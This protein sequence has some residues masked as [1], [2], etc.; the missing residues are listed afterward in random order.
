MTTS[1][2]TNQRTSVWK[3]N[4]SQ[5]ARQE[6]GEQMPD[7]NAMAARPRGVFSTADGKNLEIPC[8]PDVP[9]EQVCASPLLGN[10]VPQLPH[11][12][13]S[14]L[15][16]ETDRVS[17][18]SELF[19][20]AGSTSTCDPERIGRWVGDGESIEDPIGDQGPRVCDLPNGRLNR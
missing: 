18:I 20:R 14:R 11:L 9:F 13:L 16:A 3:H 17:S 4:T 10:D 8:A 15:D 1:A 5:R 2:E 6:G 12:V 7:L 19:E